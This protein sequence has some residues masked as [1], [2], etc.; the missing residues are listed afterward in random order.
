[1][2]IHTWHKESKKEWD[3]FA[4]MWVKKSQEMWETGSRKKIIPFFSSHVHSGMKVADIGC[5]DGVGSLKLAEAGYDVIGVDLSS[6]MIEF[7]KGKAANHPNLSFIQGDLYNLP[8]K[9]EEMDAAMVIN[10]LEYTGEPLTVMKEIWRV[11]KPGGHVCFGILGPTAEPRKNFSYQRLLG[12]D[13][14]MNTM[15]PWEFEKLA[16]ETGWKTVADTGVAKRGVDYTK[17]GHFSKD[18]KQAVSF[19]WVFL[20]QKEVAG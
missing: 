19:M 14:I 11:M 20:L 8:F 10:S 3:D 1:M 7:A 17:L 5:G 12:N 4:P 2:N 6:V 9:D 18:L 13:V 15:L 16:T